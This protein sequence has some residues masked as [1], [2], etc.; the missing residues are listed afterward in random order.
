MFKLVTISTPVVQPKEMFSGMDG[1]RYV[2]LH[3]SVC[4]FCFLVIHC[5]LLRS[6]HPLTILRTQNTRKTR[7][8]NLWGDCRQFSCG[9]L[10]WLHEPAALNPSGNHTL[11]WVWVQVFTFAVNCSHLRLI[12]ISVLQLIPWS[13]CLG[14][15]RFSEFCSNCAGLWKNANSNCAPEDPI[16]CIKL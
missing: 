16:L 4:D 8:A 2:W 6:F 5:F 11:V 12:P 7:T 9:L 1:L 10:Q 3:P 14:L 13:F 15:Q